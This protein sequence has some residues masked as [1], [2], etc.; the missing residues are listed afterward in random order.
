[1]SI[2]LRI[3]ILEDRS[4]D[5]EL[6]LNELRRAGYD[7]DWVRVETEQDYLT[8]LDSAPD[9]ILTDYRLPQFD[10]PRALERR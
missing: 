9:I 3:L 10:A 7:P 8:Y 2:P 1:V 4:S 5:T 6:I